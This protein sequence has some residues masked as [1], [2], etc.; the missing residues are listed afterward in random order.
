LPSDEFRQYV[1][2]CVE[3]FRNLSVYAA[4]LVS[5]VNCF[6]FIQT[7]EMN[8]I[9]L[10]FVYLILGSCV[11]VFAQSTVSHSFVNQGVV[12]NY[13]VY[14]PSS[15]DGSVA[16]PVVFNLHGYS[17]D[18]AAQTFYGDFRPIADTAGFLVVHPNGTLDAS[19]N[20]FW[21]AFNSPGINDVQFFDA[22]ID[23][24]NV[25]YTIDL[26][27]IFSCGMS[28]GG[29]M[30]YEL[31]CQ[32]GNRIAAVANVTGSMGYLRMTACNPQ[33]PTPAMHI[34]GT[35]DMTVPYNGSAQFAA[36]DDV[37]DFWVNQTNASNNSIF[38][39]WPD[40]DPSDGC[41][42]EW[43]IYENGDRGSS[44]ELFKVIGGGHTWP[45]A[46]VNI[47]VTNQD[48]SASEQIWRFFRQFELQEL[49][50][51]DQFESMFVRIYPNPSHGQLVIE[52][53]MQLTEIRIH[54]SA[55][56]L[57]DH[58]LLENKTSVELQLNVQPGM[59]FFSAYSLAGVVQQT[60]VVN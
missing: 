39:Q 55:G 15:Y 27:R 7:N 56:R 20:R 24:L 35:A 26:N 51:V 18:N 21:N 17:S 59:Y 38:M 11:G 34:H 29:F 41:T 37:V 13:T 2:V 1:S 12:R 31:A 58:R 3:C 53:P 23:S 5:F 10:T 9:K 14:I 4:N 44:V 8:R 19:S 50:A 6:I 52:S 22:L 48:F 45:G 32:L 33:K 54:D 60:I 30:S 28:N 40:H 16:Y 47:G 36:I 49:L 42:A 25:Q 43:Y 57:V 46:P